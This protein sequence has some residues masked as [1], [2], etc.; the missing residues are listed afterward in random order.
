MK[1]QINIPESIINTCKVSKLNENQTKEIFS[2]YM[3]E[4]MNDPYGQF[5]NDFVNWINS[6]ED[7]EE[8]N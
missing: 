7:E 8:N 6:E 3:E 2:K 1:V 4:I 5:Q